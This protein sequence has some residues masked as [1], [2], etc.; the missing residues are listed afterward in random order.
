MPQ[1]KPHRAKDLIQNL[2]PQNTQSTIPCTIFLAHWYG[3]SGQR[4]AVQ[5][6]SLMDQ[7]PAATLACPLDLRADVELS[8]V[9][10]VQRRFYFFRHP[11]ELILN[12]SI[13]ELICLATPKMLLERG[14]IL[15]RS[16]VKIVNL[17]RRSSNQASKA[18]FQYLDAMEL[19]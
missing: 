11:S 6:R 9:E 12:K 8:L 10:E 7:S 13:A 3:E 4:A 2:F 15:P 1:Q 16:R 19:R 14:W 17:V 5:L 18:L